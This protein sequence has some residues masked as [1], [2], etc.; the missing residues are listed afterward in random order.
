LLSDAKGVLWQAPAEAIF[1]I[2]RAEHEGA[3]DETL[4][5]GDKVRLKSAGA[6]STIDLFLERATPRTAERR[7]RGTGRR[8][9]V[10]AR[11]ERPRPHHPRLDA[12]GRRLLYLRTRRVR[13]KPA[14]DLCG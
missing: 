8:S 2:A 14:V 5:P 9:R 6:L 11:R 7:E 4:S 10:P 3:Y 12:A 13:F 1:E